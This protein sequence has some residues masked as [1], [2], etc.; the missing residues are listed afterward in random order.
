MKFTCEK[1]VLAQSLSIVAKAANPASAVEILKGVKIDAT[2]NTIRLTGSDLELFIESTFD[3]DVKE[4]GSLVLDARIF[5]DIVKR[6]PDGKIE[7]SSD[8]TGV[9]TIREKKVKFTLL[10][11]S[12]EGYPKMNKIEGGRELKLYSRDLKSIIKDTL[13]AISTN[14]NKPILTGSKFEVEGSTLTV[15]S[16]DGYRLA[17][18]RQ[19][20]PEIKG[21]GMEFVVPGKVLS[22]LLK[23][24]KD[25]ETIIDIVIEENNVMFRYDHYTIIT[26]LLEGE[27]IDY[28]KIIPVDR[29]TTLTVDV[30][31]VT[32]S[33]ERAAVMVSYDNPD[34]P[35]ILNIADSSILVSCQ[36]KRGDFNDAVEVGMEGANLR[37]G[38]AS[39]LLLDALHAVE[40][41]T[42]I[43]EFNSSLSPCVIKPVEG[44]A[45][46][47]MVLPIRLKN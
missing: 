40:V 10:A 44:N 19:V 11:L 42:A 16:V 14:E 46:L 23:I 34:I 3:A 47:Y 38:L 22:E 30:K 39:K 26:R 17:I 31:K 24:L 12:A 45:F 15:I 5:S 1:D 6:M 27:F 33:I 41:P 43:L 36:T 20:I 37:I 21:D 28:K 29:Q 9:V 2:E 8:D 4:T 7:F 32:E 13:F 25:D 35:I 18:R